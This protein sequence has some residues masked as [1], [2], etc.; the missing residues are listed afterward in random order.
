[1]LTKEQIALE[2]EDTK[3]CPDCKEVK[4]LFEFGVSFNGRKSSQSFCIECEKKRKR[5]DH[6]FQTYGISLKDYDKMLE[7]QGGKCKI[8]GT[9]TPRGYG[10]FHVDHCHTTNKIRGLLCHYCNT[11]L[12]N[13]KDDIKILASAIQYLTDSR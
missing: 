2:D 4:P 1:M 12:G 11:L 3:Y 13:C 6:I 10:R 8:C 7:K 5:E 9:K